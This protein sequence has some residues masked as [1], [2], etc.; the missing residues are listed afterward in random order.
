MW[1]LLKK[2]KKMWV[3]LMVFGKEVLTKDLSWVPPDGVLL[4]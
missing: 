3:C 1:I 4:S 2:S